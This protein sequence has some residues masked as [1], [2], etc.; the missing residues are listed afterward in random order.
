[1][2]ST[3]CLPYDSIQNCRLYILISVLYI[4][5]V[6]P[7]KTNIQNIIRTQYK[8]SAEQNNNTLTYGQLLL[9]HQYSYFWPLRPST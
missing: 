2:F 8:W 5:W 9:L 4:L 7:L 6:I 3:Q 1:V